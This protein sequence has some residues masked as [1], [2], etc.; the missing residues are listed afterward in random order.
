[1]RFNGL[2]LNLLVALNA[3]LN[4]GSVTVAA[5]SI[6]LSQ[7]AMSAAIQRLRQYFDD[8]LF[9]MNGRER[10]FTPR[11]ESLAPA[12]RDILSR[13]QSSVIGSGQFDPEN[14]SRKFRII[15]S[16][17]VTVVFIG[18]AINSISKSLPTLKFEL[19]APD[20]NYHDLIQRSE[21][22]MLVMP[23]LFLSSNQPCAPIFEEKL[24]CVAC[25]TNKSARG[26]ITFEK[27]MS[28]KHVSAKFGRG[29][30]PSIEEWFMVE[31]GIRRN[32]D[33]TVQSFG[34]IPQLVCGTDRVAIMP[35]KLVRHAM[36]RRNLNIINLPFPLPKFTESMQWPIHAE[37]DLGNQW[38]RQFLLREALSRL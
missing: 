34:M 12:V 33:V 30:R 11:A 19:I 25:R 36:Y 4:E 24:V 5:K 27:Y 7:P 8:D 2:D 17:Y 1:M 28:M 18:P 3:L 6:N 37:G 10:I 32:I 20:D 38:L 29:M 14:T 23:E 26:D 35:L 13:I 22:D 31:N 16:D 21:V 9:L 15:A